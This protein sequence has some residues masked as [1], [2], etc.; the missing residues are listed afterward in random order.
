MHLS[1]TA[2]GCYLGYLAHRYEENSEE[3]VKKLL[4]KYP[5]APVQWAAMVTEPKGEGFAI[6][7]RPNT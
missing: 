1:F 5:R 2:L 4:E 3:R 6:L 7:G